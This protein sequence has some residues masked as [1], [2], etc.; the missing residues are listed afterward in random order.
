MFLPPAG[1]S[2]LP[3][4]RT[5]GPD[6][7]RRV[8]ILLAKA[9]DKGRHWLGVERELRGEQKL[10]SGCARCRELPVERAGGES[11]PGNSPMP[12]KVAGEDDTRKAELPAPLSITSSAEPKVPRAPDD[13]SRAPVRRPTFGRDERTPGRSLLPAGEVARHEIEPRPPQVRRGIPHYV[14]RQVRQI[15]DEH[16]RARGDPLDHR[17]AGRA[18]AATIS[19]E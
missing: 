15:R 3:I 7:E 5:G 11:H 17:G 4:G 9:A 14:G 16:L 19:I 6:P 2:S 13:R 1:G 10:Y 8:D 12:L 18:V